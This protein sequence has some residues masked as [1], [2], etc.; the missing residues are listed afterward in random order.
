MSFRSEPRTK[1]FGAP[2]RADLRGRTSD[3]LRRDERATRRFLIAQAAGKA[4]GSLRAI[5]EFVA[6]AIETG[7]L[8]QGPVPSR[9]TIRHLQAR[10]AGGEQSISDYYDAPRAGRPRTHLDTAIEDKVHQVI[11][12]GRAINAHALTGFLRSVAEERDL[13]AP[14]YRQIHRRF[15]EA[16]RLVRAASRY[17]SRAGEI[18]G[19]PHARVPSRHSH[20][21]WALDELTMPVWVR[22]YDSDTGWVSARSDV[23]IVIDVCSTAVVGYH[24]ADP[25]ERIHYDGSPFRGGFDADDVLAALLSAACPEFASD[26]TREFAGYLPDRIRWDNAA[27]H[28]SLE[29]QLLVAGIDIDVRPIRPRRAASNGAAERRVAILK[30]HCAEI[31]GHVDDYLPTD[32]VDTPEDDVARQ[33]TFASGYTSEREPRR[34]PI[35]PEQLHSVEELRAIF[36]GV[37]RRYNYDLQNRMHRMAPVHK[38]HRDRHQR[39][40]RRGLDLMR[41]IEPRTVR[42]GSSGILHTINGVTN[43]FYPLLE[44]TLLLVDQPVTYRAHPHGTGLF[45]ERD[46]RL[47]YLRPQATWSDTEAAEIAVSHSAAARMISDNADSLREDQLMDRVG[48][49]GVDAA[50]DEYEQR[51]EQSRT[52]STPAPPAEPVD[53]TANAPR[54]APPNPW[55]NNDPITFLGPDDYS[56]P[57][58]E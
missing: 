27:A 34:I 20:D 32:Q 18:D 6:S 21:T 58:S 33:R 8:P 51:L 54:S 57:N 29:S 2:S 50:L 7:L 12:S 48:Q 26:A 43:Q 4:T 19:L 41:M 46:N 47:I 10:W 17:G 42:V 37:V 36:D 44:G 30:T 53:D 52:S 31:H 25:S 11:H 45:V 24:L 3:A 13:T 1:A 38:Y 39:R 49:E 35:L 55:L 28:K 16:G 40:P 56:H 23:A 15:S 14:S 9:E 22:V 5:Q